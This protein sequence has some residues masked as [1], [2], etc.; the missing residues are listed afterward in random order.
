MR[1]AL[2]VVFL[3]AGS[4]IAA[5]EPI[6]LPDPKEGQINGIVA[7]MFWPAKNTD[8]GKVD[9]LLPVE[10]CQV[11]LAP[12]T[13]LPAER[14]YRCGTWFQPPE[15]RYRVWLEKSGDRI[16]Q[17]TGTFNYAPEPF[18][19]R[20][21]GVVMPVG[22][23]GRVALASD[24]ALP[25][26][27]ELRL[28]NFDSC[29]I[30]PKLTHPFDR[31]A[32]SS[33]RELRSGLLLPT[34]RV[35]SGIF[36]RATNEA[37]AIAPL[38]RVEAGKI[39]IVAPRP[40]GAGTS[41]VFLSLGRP[42]VRKKLDVDVIALTLDGKKPDALFDGSDRI[43]AA[44]F[45]VKGPS[46]QLASD[47]KTLRLTPRTLKLSPGRVVTVR[48]E[49]QKL[50]AVG[51]SLLAPEGA[52]DGEPVRVEAR[53]PAHADALRGEAI[54]AGDDVR[55]EALPAEPL[56]IVL[57]V[58]PWR[59]RER[60]DLS[61][62]VD[63]KVVFDLHPIIVSGEVF[64]GREHAANAEVA[65]EADDGY[66]RVKCDDAGRYRA[67]LWHGNDAALAEVTVPG[68][69]G[70]PFVEGF[71]QIDDSRTL[72]FHVPRTRYIVRAVD[73]ESGRAIAG[74]EIFAANVFTHFS[75]EEMKLLQHATTGV[76]GV[77]SLA[78]LRRGKLELRA[79]ADGYVDS[80]MIDGSVEHEE[81]EGE[82][83]V[84]LRSVG[85]TVRVQ[86]HMD[87]GRPV[88]DAEL[89]AVAATHGIQRPLWRGSSDA[90]GMI[91]VPRNVD[92][93][94]LLI[95]SRGAA[96]AV[97]PF[98]ADAEERAIVLHAAASPIRIDTGRAQT[99]IALWID[100]VRITGPAVTF[101]AWSSE[102]NDGNG[103]WFAENLPRQPLRVLAW[104]DTP[105]SEIAAGTRDA[106]AATVPYPWPPSITLR[107]AQ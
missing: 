80:Q 88:G 71:V 34:G 98:H 87:D 1:T 13:D 25:R 49:L 22:A 106:S 44:W 64:Y 4:I 2:C 66:V 105:E 55:L 31:R 45:G 5:S 35:F 59:F 12:W 39:A 11:V 104:R 48:E 46:A 38:V 10:D 60:I 75:G 102:V 42:D 26:D 107:V 36:D 33:T 29:C 57:R 68:R 8:G 73:A 81:S 82:L 40:P 69:A 50:P 30:A 24:V 83:E 62:G 84:R 3:I 92:G 54:R 19:G 91:D 52:L 21:H 32:I 14:T 65:F 95:R 17:T 20:G 103:Q 15:G 53:R 47:S 61:S 41:D 67:T 43:Y 86:L 63:E 101:L 78:P 97:R 56:D 99:R 51:V 7:V 100:G 37:I 79:R 6:R 16:T 90:N 89:W 77:A 85:E 27:T 23:G 9:Q 28:F 96:S 76:D 18:Q 70:P 72:D 93:A 58:G 74:A 94:T